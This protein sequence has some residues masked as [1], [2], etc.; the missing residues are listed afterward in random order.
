VRARHV[1]FG[2]GLVDE[3]QAGR[4]NFALVLAPPASSSS[5]VGSI[6]FAGMQAFLKLMPSCS[7]KCQT[8]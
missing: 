5:D 4:I 2:P 6:L 1:C 3:D 8:A 7:K